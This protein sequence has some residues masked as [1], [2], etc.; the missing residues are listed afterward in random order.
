MHTPRLTESRI[1]ERAS[2]GT[3]SSLVVNEGGVDSAS[4]GVLIQ[5]IFALR[6]ALASGLSP[7]LPNPTY[8]TMAISAS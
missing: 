7:V 8:L 1:F 6:C 2:S 5:D 3:W 4:W